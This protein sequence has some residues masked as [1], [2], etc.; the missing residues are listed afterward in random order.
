SGPSTPSIVWTAHPAAWIAGTRQL[1]TRTPSRKTEHAPHSP[2]PQPS[3]VPV[4]S[5]SSLKTSRSRRIGW[6][7]TDRSSPLTVRVSCVV[8]PRSAIALL[9][10][11]HHLLGCQRDAIE[12]PTGR[13]LDCVEDRRRRAVHRELADA[14]R[15]GG[16]VR[17][18]LLREEDADRRH[19]C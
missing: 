17:R 8:A 18:G 11:S 12:A 14:F 7:S 13:E 4:S 3:F 2:S 15:S 5:R 1:L 6:T 10:A 9:Q 16:A 19:V